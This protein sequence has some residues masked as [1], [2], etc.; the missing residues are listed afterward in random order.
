[1]YFKSHLTVVCLLVL[2]SFSTADR[3]PCHPDRYL[4]GR[5][6]SC[7][8]TVVPPNLCKRCQFRPYLPNGN[9]KNCSAIYDLDASAC[10]RQLV[11]YAELN[12]CDAVRNRQVKDISANIVPLD[13]FVYAICEECCDCIPRNSKL[14]EYKQRRKDNTLLKADRANCPL[15]AHYDIC[16]VW[17]QV[18]YVKTPFEKTPTDL[19]RKWPAV[20]PIFKN[21]K[22]GP[23]GQNLYNAD[24]TKIS[25]S[26]RAFLERFILAAKCKNKKLWNSCFALEKAQNRV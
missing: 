6:V 20:C 7:E 10:R 9:F 21:W 23:N 22:L 13:Y 18:R 5:E 12:P 14:Q 24:E 11:Q 3:N 4:L 2:Y 15:H 1:M 26:L 19:R 16:R 8:V 17:P 25:N